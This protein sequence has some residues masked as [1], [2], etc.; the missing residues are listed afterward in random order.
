MISKGMEQGIKYFETYP[1][2]SKGHKNPNFF[3]LHII[4]YE[5]L[6]IA[7]NRPKINVRY[8]KN[9]AVK[10]HISHVSNKEKNIF[11]DETHRLVYY[12]IVACIGSLSCPDC[13]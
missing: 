13:M 4:I 1:S 9:I 3:Q 10:K 8:V 7:K 5:N 6:S 11:S 2:N 12:N